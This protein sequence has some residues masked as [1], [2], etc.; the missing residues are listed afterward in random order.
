[1]TKQRA[2]FTPMPKKIR[3][4]K[5]A[6]ILWTAEALCAQY[7]KAKRANYMLCGPQ[8]MGMFISFTLNLGPIVSTG[9]AINTMKKKIYSL[10][11]EKDGH[12]LDKLQDEAMFR[13][14]MKWL[15]DSQL[16][17][18]AGSGKHLATIAA[19]ELCRRNERNHRVYTGYIIQ[20]VS[21]RG[22]LNLN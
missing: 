5:L 3:P 8:K 9:K 14:I 4:L 10:L 22:K 19:T 20:Y 7:S 21:F 1:M 18:I 2:I 11:A 17:E 16:T 6:A 12:I 15:N 13:P